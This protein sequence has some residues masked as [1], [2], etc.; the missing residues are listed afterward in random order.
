MHKIILEMWEFC[1]YFDDSFSADTFE[2]KVASFAKMVGGIV[3]KVLSRG[4]FSVLVAV[5]FEKRRDATKFFSE[6]LAE[7]ILKGYKK[8]YIES[9]LNFEKTNAENFS[10]FLQALVCFDSE[11]DKSIILERLRLRSEFYLTSFVSFKL[12]F[13][14]NK[15]NELISLANDNMVYLL[16]E[17]SC[18]ELIKFLI[19]NLEHRYYAVNIFSKD[20][21]YLLCDMQGRAIED[22]LID[23]HTIY[24]DDNLITSLVA[25]N[26]EKI[27][28]HCNKSS[29]DKLIKNLFNFFPSQIEICK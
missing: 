24:D 8:E 27:I 3:A 1:F 7:T 29:K 2:L 14:K 18:V 4:Y 26:P 20:D 12:K 6:K 16:N 21:C 23:K 28:V 13:L 19:S 10:V 15:W 9:S 22:F 11:I 17:D 5:P 25:L